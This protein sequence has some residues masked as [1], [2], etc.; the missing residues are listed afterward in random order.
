MQCVEKSIEQIYCKSECVAVLHVY[1]YNTLQN[2]LNTVT[3]KKF[4][5]HTEFVTKISN[6]VAPFSQNKRFKVIA[7]IHY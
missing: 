1:L 4:T 3:F 5:N 2:Y 6:H 7:F